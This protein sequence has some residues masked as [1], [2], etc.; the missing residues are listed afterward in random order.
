[1]F[2]KCNFLPLYPTFREIAVF[3]SFGYSIYVT[4]MTFKDFF[5]YSFFWTSCFLLKLFFIF[6]IFGYRSDLNIL[7]DM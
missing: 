3:L 5:S 4:K 6:R 7:I 2:P 1:M